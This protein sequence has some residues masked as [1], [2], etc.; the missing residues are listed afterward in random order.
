MRL[1]ARLWHGAVPGETA[2]VPA[3]GPAILVANHPNHSDPCFLLATSP[4]PIHFLQTQED[5]HIPVLWRIYRRFGLIPVR[6][7][8]RDV[9]GTRAALRDLKAGGVIGV[10][11]EGQVTQCNGNGALRLKD[12]AALLALRARAPVIPAWIHGGPQ[13]H[14][15]LTDWL[16]PSRGVRVSFGSPIDLKALEDRPLTRELLREVSEL[17]LRRIRELEPKPAAASDSTGNLKSA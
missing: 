1:F 12:G 14:G 8:G 5:Y 4:R 10:F 6:R 3:R 13:R 15:I 11:P 2:P 16:I 17:F 9:A 7:D